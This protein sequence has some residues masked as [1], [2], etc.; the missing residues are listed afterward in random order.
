MVCCL[1]FLRTR[2]PTLHCVSCVS[3]YLFTVETR[4]AFEYTAPIPPKFAA[5]R[6]EM[7]RLLN[8]AECHG[9][10]IIYCRKNLL[11]LRSDPQV[12]EFAVRFP[13][14]EHRLVLWTAGQI[15]KHHEEW[16]ARQGSRTPKHEQSTTCTGSG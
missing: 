1:Q 6:A 5:L 3:V 7:E 15:R 9:D 2:R 11:M 16:S 4:Q 10:L 8:V 12:R 13:S 14:S